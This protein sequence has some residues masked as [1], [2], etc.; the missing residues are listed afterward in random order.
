MTLSARLEAVV[1]ELVADLVGRPVGVRSLAARGFRSAWAGVVALE[2]GS[3]TVFVKARSGPSVAGLD[4][5]REVLEHLPPGLG[6]SVRGSC[7]SSADDVA[8]L[9]LEDLSANYWPPP[10]DSGSIGRTVELLGRVAAAGPAAGV[11]PRL[12]DVATTLK[13]WATLSADPAP[14]LATGL[15]SAA[16]LDRYLPALVDMVFE[17]S[18]DGDGLV[19]F[20]VRSDNI[21][22]GP[23][24][25]V[26]VDWEFSCLGNP[27]VDLLSW[28]PSLRAE[29]GPE[30][31]VVA[32]DAEPALVAFLAGYWSSQA[33]LPEPSGTPGLRDLQRAQASVALDWLDRS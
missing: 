6:P 18:L 3:E 25:A 15:R 33:G 9:V 21:S 10:W 11:M 24:G 29:G 30:P 28:L 31:W 12:V 4:H 8:V 5:E 17:D 13:S 20:D 23:A 14:F 26:L 1:L 27:R 32:P 7:A 16:W 22:L 2:G 19:H